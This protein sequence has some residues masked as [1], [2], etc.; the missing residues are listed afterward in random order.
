LMNGQL[1]AESE[2]D[3]GSVFHFTANFV[4]S[5]STQSSQPT[6]PV[7][8]VNTRAL[9][10]DDNATN[11]RVLG[12]MLASWGMEPCM[13]ESG[14]T[15]QFMLQ[16]SLDKDQP[17]P[18]IIIDAQMPGVDGFAVAETIKTEPRFAAST[19]IMLITAGQRGDVAQNSDLR[20]SAY[21][22]KPASEADLL[23]ALVHKDT[24]K[25]VAQKPSVQRQPQ[26]ETQS[27]T[28]DLLLAEDN[29]V[30]QKLAIRLLERLGYKVVLVENGLQAVAATDK[31]VF[32]LI[33]MDVQMPEMGGFEATAIIREKEKL[34]GR[35]TPIIAMTAHALQGDRDKCIEAGM[36]DYLSKP[37]RA[38]QLK[39]MIEKYLNI[40]PMVVQSTTA[41][42]A[43]AAAAATA[44]ASALA[45]PQSSESGSSSSRAALP[46]LMASTDVADKSLL[47]EIAPVFLV[48]YPRLMVAIDQSVNKGDFDTLY[49]ASHSLK[50]AVSNFSSEAMKTAFELQM[51]GKTNGS[52]VEAAKLFVQ[53]E[54]DISNLLPVIQNLAEQHERENQE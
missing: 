20:I 7:Y 53:L 33:L 52:L 25:N 32:D 22:T 4:M 41:A 29:P 36:D 14:E 12:S 26:Q 6:P 10:V 21:V 27:R 39:L 37:I 24:A 8:L 9:I 44:N 18:L 1:H 40:L 19:I 34:L 31:K 17:Y 15:A 46:P 42:A 45:A 2:V 11:R 30:N 43:A 35:H 38:D 51:I 47:C 48:E 5:K 13:A 50:G 54:R 49:R 28:A 23:N 16:E 3:Q